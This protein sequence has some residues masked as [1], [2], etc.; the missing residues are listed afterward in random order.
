MG[1]TQNGTSGNYTY[2]T[3]NGNKPVTYV[4]FWDAARFTNW[5]SNGQAAGVQGTTATETGKYN[6]PAR[7]QSR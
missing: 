5:L 4:S 6:P 1:I 3:A 2:S 7:F